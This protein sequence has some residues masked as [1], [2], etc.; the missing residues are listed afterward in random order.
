M[1]APILPGEQILF[2]LRTLGINE[3]PYPVFAT[4]LAVCRGALVVAEADSRNGLATITCHRGSESDGTYWYEYV[5]QKGV[6]SSLN[7]ASLQIVNDPNGVNGEKTA[8]RSF[9]FE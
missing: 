8:T 5:N 9:V 2:F 1:K 6:P 4:V 7:V 3:K